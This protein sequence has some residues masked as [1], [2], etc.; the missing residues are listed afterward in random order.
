[1]ITLPKNAADALATIDRLIDRA[2]REAPGHESAFL[3]HHIRDAV[4]RRI[5]LER[6]RAQAQPM[7]LA[8]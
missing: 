6:L 5:V 8:A 3:I 2:R 7:S 4:Q 1:M